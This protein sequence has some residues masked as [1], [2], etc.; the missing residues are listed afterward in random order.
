MSEGMVVILQMFRRES[1]RLSRNPRDW[2]VPLGG[3]FTV[4]LVH[5]TTASSVSDSVGRE[6][7]GKEPLD[8]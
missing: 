2:L 3:S 7:D 8:S 1:R 4:L 6:N 5:P